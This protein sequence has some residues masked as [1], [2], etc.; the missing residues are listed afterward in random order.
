MYRRYVSGSHLELGVG[1]GY[2]LQ[3]SGV[4]SDTRLALVDRHPASLQVAGRQLR[5]AAPGLYRR[6][7]LQPLRLGARTF[8]SVGM[9][10]LL[11][12]LPGDITDKSVVFDHLQPHLAA[13]AVIFGATLL[14]CNDQQTSLSSGLMKLYNATGV[15]SNSE[16]K[17]ADLRTELEERFRES[18]VEA[19]GSAAPFRAWP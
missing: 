16:D 11:H 7:V 15:F 4:T 13:D 17:L 3:Q 6:D 12:C 1:T 14:R 5:S 8:S 18:H 2:L 9:N 19:V 10:Y